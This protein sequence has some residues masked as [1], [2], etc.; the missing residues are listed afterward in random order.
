MDTSLTTGKIL[1]AIIAYG[2]IVYELYSNRHR[3]D[4]VWSIWKRMRL[5]MV[6]ETIVVVIFTAATTV[7]LISYIPFMG[8]G[9]ANIF[10]EGG[11]NVLV[12]PLIETSYSSNFYA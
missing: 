2:S 8:W 6:L 7:S 4:F 3:M 12:R 1:F 10:F 5:G 11:G 9:W